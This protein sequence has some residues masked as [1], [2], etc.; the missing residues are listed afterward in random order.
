MKRKILKD[1]VTTH[2]GIC[3]CI[4]EPRGDHG[5]EGYQLGEFY[6]YDLRVSGCGKTFYK[7]YPDKNFASYG[8]NCSRKHFNQFFKVKLDKPS[9]EDEINKIMIAAI[10]FKAPKGL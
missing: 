8:E 3:E 9:F 5:L 1:C 10:N 7:I 4:N 6:K 2:T